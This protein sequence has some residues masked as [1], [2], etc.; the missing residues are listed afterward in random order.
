[1]HVDDNNRI[2]SVF[3]C[4]GEEIA[5]DELA[6]TYEKAQFQCR[7]LGNIERALV[8]DVAA[9][10]TWMSRAREW[11]IWDFALGAMRIVKVGIG[12][13]GE[14]VVWKNPAVIGQRVLHTLLDDGKWIE[15]INHP[16]Y[17]PN[18]RVLL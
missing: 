2:V 3:T 14:T 17:E 1:M 10:D 16:R 6:R 7:V 9:G 5:I 18:S 12:P 13:G 15:G 4:F 11:A 8:R